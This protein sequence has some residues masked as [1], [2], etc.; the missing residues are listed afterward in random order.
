MDSLI[1][2]FHIDWKLLIAQI[3]NFG[4]VLAVLWYFALKPLLKT[5]KDR[6]EEIDASL[7]NAEK[8]KENLTKV[9][10]DKD[11]IL[12]AAK[13]E[14]QMIIEESRKQG[15]EQ[16]EQM[17]NNAKQEVQAV[18][19]TAKEQINTAK[20]KMLVDAKAEVGDLVIQATKKILEKTGSKELDEKMVEKTLKE[21]KS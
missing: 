17:V 5:M 16:G 19:A 15:N 18:I 8:I 7:K 3:V 4:I 2:T 1:T 10:K 6:G 9:E 11:A 20:E 21:L 14:A 12:M 13:K